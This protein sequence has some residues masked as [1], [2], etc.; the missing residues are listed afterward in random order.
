M[1]RVVSIRIPWTGETQELK[2]TSKL[3]LCYPFCN[4]SQPWRGSLQE[5]GTIESPGTEDNQLAW[6]SSWALRSAVTASR[7]AHYLIRTPRPIRS[8]LA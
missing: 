8:L 5:L 7:L 6:I 1:L 3:P 2:N 4:K